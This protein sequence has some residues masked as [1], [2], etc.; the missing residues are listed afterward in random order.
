MV[1]RLEIPD[2]VVE[3]SCYLCTESKGADQLCG[4]LTAD[5]RLCFRTYK[6][7]FSHEAA[8]FFMFPKDRTSDNSDTHTFTLSKKMKCATFLVTQHINNIFKQNIRLCQ[9]KIVSLNE[10]DTYFVTIRN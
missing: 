1:K 7:R 6:S 3:G 8:L 2:L 4:H 5:L 10:P 9:L